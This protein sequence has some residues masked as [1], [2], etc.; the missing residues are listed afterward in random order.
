MVSRL[1][2]NLTQVYTPLFLQKTLD[3]RKVCLNFI[4]N[5][6]INLNGI[7]IS[8]EYSNHPIRHLHQWI[9]LVSRLKVYL[10]QNRT[11]GNSCL[12]KYLSVIELSKKNSNL[13]KSLLFEVLTSYK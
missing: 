5:I 11:K 1:F 13:K 6:E 8:D 9:H 7:C 12:M 10:W 3:L 4:F 2:V